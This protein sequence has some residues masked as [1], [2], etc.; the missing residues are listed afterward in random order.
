[1]LAARVLA[2]CTR[3]VRRSVASGGVAF[4]AVSSLAL[5]CGE[6]VVSAARVERLHWTIDAATRA[7]AYACAPRELALARA[8]YDFVQVELAHGNPRRALQ[9]LEVAE[10]N[11]GAA[12]V[13]TPE[14]GCEPSPV[15]TSS[16]WSPLHVPVPVVEDLTHGPADGQDTAAAGAACT[17]DGSTE[18]DGCG[19]LAP[20]HSALEV[21]TGLLEYTQPAS[22]IVPAH[23]GYETSNKQESCSDVSDDANCPIHPES[24]VSI[25]ARELLLSAPIAFDGDSAVLLAPSQRVLDAIAQV[26]TEHPSMTL[27]IAAYSDNRGDAARNRNL[28]QEQA[29][30]VRA[31]LIERGVAAPRLTAQGYGETRPIESNSTS[32]GRA[33]NRRIELIRTER[34]P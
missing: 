15:N 11:A 29:D 26:L 9:H 4:C 13:L 18:A 17:S 12:Q 8:H 31:Y 22:P 6:P 5:A 25:A 28:S 21:N 27:E 33:T 23:I 7:G 16:A 3:R 20:A 1:M 10:E 2:G 32:R 30:S 24:P 19:A 14:R 34:A